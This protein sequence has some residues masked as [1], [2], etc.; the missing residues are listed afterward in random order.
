MLTTVMNM[1]SES[2]VSVLMFGVT[3]V[4][5]FVVYCTKWMKL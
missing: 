5:C 4:I 2:L 3:G 1:L